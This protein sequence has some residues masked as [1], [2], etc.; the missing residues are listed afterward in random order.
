VDNSIRRAFAIRLLNQQAIRSQL[1]NMGIIRRF[2]RASRLD[3]YR[4]DDP[5]L[6]Y[7]IIRLAGQLERR[8]VKRAFYSAPAA[9]VGVDDPSVGKSRFAALHPRLP[10]EDQSQ[11]KKEKDEIE[12]ENQ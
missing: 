10:E 1:K 7:K 4:D 6:A 9:C 11:E 2:G 3:L 12:H 5:I 8:I